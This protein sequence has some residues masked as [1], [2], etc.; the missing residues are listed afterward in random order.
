NILAWSTVFTPGQPTQPDF[1]KSIQNFTAADVAQDLVFAAD[2][3]A[4]FT[5]GLNKALHQ[6]KLAAAAPTKNFA[7]PNNVDA[8]AF[9]PGGKLFATGCH[10]GKLRL[11]DYDKGLVKEINAHTVANQ[12]MIY[13]VVFTADGKQVL[14]ASY[15][16]SMKL[17]DVASGNLVREFKGFKAKD[18]EKG[19]QESVF[20]AA[21]SPDGKFLASGSGGLERVIKIWNVADGTVVRDLANPSIKTPPNQ[22]ASHPGW[23]YNLRFTKDG[24]LISAGDA[25]GDKGYL[26]VW[27]PADGKMLFG[28]AMP[29]GTFFGLALS[30]TD[31]KTIAIGAGPRGRPTPNFNSAF[32][33]KVPVLGN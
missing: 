5:G 22:V 23:I 16:N 7:H 24:K 27:N 29:L 20:S 33:M 32:L 1:L 4:F 31:G 21:F 11:F 14:T 12:T 8:I 19:H 18:F 25:P 30:P 28:E 26:A 15:D 10:D 3:A 9:Q 17:F 2:N 6:W 13:Q